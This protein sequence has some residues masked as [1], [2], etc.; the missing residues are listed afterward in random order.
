VSTFMAVWPRINRPCSIADWICRQ[1][2]LQSLVL[3]VKE[4]C[5]LQYDLPFNSCA[6]VTQ[7]GAPRP[8]GSSSRHGG[9]A[10]RGG[11]HDTSGPEAQA[12]VAGGGG[13]AA[14]R[15]K[16]EKREGASDAWGQAAAQV[17]G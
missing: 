14:R 17:Q 13:K 7:A 5:H 6:W 9:G 8:L 15:K 12:V 11:A 1:S 3:W 10:A 2:S 16:G 4:S